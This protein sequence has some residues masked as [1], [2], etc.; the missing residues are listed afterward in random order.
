MTT[1]PAP[2]RMLTDT[3]RVRSY[4]IDAKG[5]LTVDT[6]CNLFQEAASRH[7]R[8]LGVG[9]DQLSALNRFWVLSQLSLKIERYPGWG[10]TLRIET[11]PSG[12]ERLFALR[13]FSL[14]TADNAPVASGISAWLVIDADRRRPLRI[15]QTL[16][17]LNPVTDIRAKA[18]PPIRLSKPMGE[19]ERKRFRT[20]YRDLDVNHH[21]NNVRYIERVVESLPS[22]QLP[23]LSLKTLQ[24]NFLAEA[25]FGDTIISHA[26]PQPQNP[27]GYDHLL[28]R[29]K[30][31]RKLA[32]AQTTWEMI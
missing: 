12:Q 26:C 20:R 8:D 24:I 17:H 16:A 14:T 25:L 23:R 21:M 7:A 6:V 18:P 5:R 31:S 2:S 15:E 32:R 13:D 30:D 28:V 3:H 19:G 10:E 22:A 29:E 27:L 9:A 11:W 4:E 1:A